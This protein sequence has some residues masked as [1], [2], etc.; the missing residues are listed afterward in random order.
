MRNSNYLKL[1]PEFKLLCE[2]EKS[3]FPQAIKY[4]LD[5]GFCLKS[6]AHSN[7]YL[8]ASWFK[9]PNNRD[10]RVFTWI[11]GKY[12]GEEAIW[13]IESSDNGKTCYIYNSKQHAY[14]HAIKDQYDDDR[15]YIVD[16]QVREMQG[17]WRIQLAAESEIILLNDYYGE[18]LYNSFKY[19]DNRRYVFTWLKGPIRSARW[20]VEVCGSSTRQRRDASD[21]GLENTDNNATITLPGKSVT[22]LLFF[23]I[24]QQSNGNNKTLE[25]SIA[26]SN[27]ETIEASTS[28]LFNYK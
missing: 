1:T 19:N 27:R 17:K 21:D 24:K 8:Y 14:L 11:P 20:Q 5:N 22:N 7:E 2:S 13:R 26:D 4:L 6:V 28:S 3:K 9:M 18:T 25:E 10:N 16:F 15:W 23:Q 12:A